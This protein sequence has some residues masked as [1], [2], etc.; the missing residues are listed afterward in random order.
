[1]PDN[2]DKITTHGSEEFFALCQ[3]IREQGLRCPYVE[4]GKRNGD[5]IFTILKPDLSQPELTINDT[6]Y[7]RRNHT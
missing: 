1:M 5:W 2:A 7:E 6:T 3:R 4:R